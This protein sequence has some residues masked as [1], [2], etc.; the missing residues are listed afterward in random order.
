[1]IAPTIKA[2]IENI[3][4]YYFSP[5]VSFPPNLDI[6]RNFIFLIII[7]RLNC[8]RRWNNVQKCIS[9]NSVH[10]DIIFSVKIGI[11][12]DIINSILL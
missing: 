11:C 3:F 7:F 8:G 6:Y 10:T 4:N 12:V 1:M 2:N 5:S 9:S